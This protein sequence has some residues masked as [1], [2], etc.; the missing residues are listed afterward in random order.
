MDIIWNQPKEVNLLKKFGKYAKTAGA[1]FIV[2][3]LLG[4]LFPIFTSYAVVIF[5][6]WMMLL[7]G[8]MAGYFTFMTDKEDWG[9]WLKSVALVGVALYMLFSPLGGIATLGLLLSIYFF[10]M[11][12]AVLCWPHR[13]IRTKAGYCGLSTRCFP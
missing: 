3:G 4:I 9:G 10:W 1:I 6:A 5:V 13:S 2:L 8:L 12:L 7:A 11:L